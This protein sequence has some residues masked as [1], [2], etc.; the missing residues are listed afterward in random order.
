[1]S[2]SH[3]RRDAVT[4]RLLSML[5]DIKQTSRDS[6]TFQDE[7][8]FLQMLDMDS[9]DAVELTLQLD[10]VFSLGFG[11]D[12]DD[13]D[14]LGSFGGLV[15]LVMTRGRLDALPDGSAVDEWV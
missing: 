6:M 10:A 2:E 5:A 11:E 1:V 9:I 7:D 12:P 14:H 3:D 15:D 4:G 13:V 8:D